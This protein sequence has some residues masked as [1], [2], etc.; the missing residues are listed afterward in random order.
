MSFDIK[1]KGYS[2]K[3]VDEY[4]AD[5][6]GV[7]AKKD[8]R[9]AELTAEVSSLKQELSKNDGKRELI[10]KAIYSALSKAE[11]IE[12][13]TKAKYDAEMARLKAFHEKWVA[14]YNNLLAK[15]PMDDE[16]M[17]VSKFNKEMTEA[18][19]APQSQFATESER[20]DAKDGSPLDIPQT[21]KDYLDSSDIAATRPG[22]DS[23]AYR[24]GIAMVNP[25]LSTPSESG[26]SF[27]EALNPTA[28]LDE[29]MKDLGLM[30]DE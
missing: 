21:L 8:E 1:R 24:T 19:G 7:S 11:Q 9:I 23:M 12:Q 10:V 22:R 27:E 3:Q 4:I 2:T 20:L 15:Y 26:F 17:A 18:M 5:L 13:L 16:L 25:A 14:Y 30:G 29:I 6:Q 28:D